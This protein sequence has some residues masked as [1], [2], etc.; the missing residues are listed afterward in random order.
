MQSNYLCYIVIISG[1][2]LTEGQIDMVKLGPTEMNRMLR[3]W[4]VLHEMIHEKY[5]VEE[6]ILV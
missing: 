2:H 3:A 1:Q 5:L 4:A 6:D